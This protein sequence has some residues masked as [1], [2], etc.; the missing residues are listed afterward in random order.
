[1]HNLDVLHLMA[2]AADDFVVEADTHASAADYLSCL[3]LVFAVVKGST[4]LVMAA[5]AAAVVHIHQSFDA[6]L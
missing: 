1:M 4:V 6:A 5:V 3:V 2:V